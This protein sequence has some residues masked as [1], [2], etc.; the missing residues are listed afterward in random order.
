MYDFFQ[1]AVVAN[2]LYLHTTYQ[3]NNLFL[4]FVQRILLGSQNNISYLVEQ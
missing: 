2:V 4:G 1:E 3:Q